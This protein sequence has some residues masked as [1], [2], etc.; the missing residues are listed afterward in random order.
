MK[1]A[2][3]PEA[4]RL[5]QPYL[6]P[7]QAQSVPPSDYENRLADAIEAAFGAGIT[8]I[9]GLVATLNAAGIA[10]FDGASWT[11]ERFK[12]EMQRLGG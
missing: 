7:R 9:D 5:P 3:F 12:S 8:D 2:F 4:D 6:E 1:S 11:G 10:T